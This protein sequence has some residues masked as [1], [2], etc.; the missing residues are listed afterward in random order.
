MA[1]IRAKLRRTSPNY[2]DPEFLRC[3]HLVFKVQTRELVIN[4]E[5]IVLTPKEAL[6]LEIFF[7]YPGL[8]LTRHQLIDRLWGYDSEVL[9]N[10]L[11]AHVSKLRRRLSAWGGPEIHTIRSLG[12]RLELES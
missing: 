2:Q 4:E 9:E 3:G 5:I 6:L 7:R 12:Y 10:T 1:R 11:E 8:V